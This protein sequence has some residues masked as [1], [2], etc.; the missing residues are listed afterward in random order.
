MP[1]NFPTPLPSNSGSSSDS[2]M[3]NRAPNDLASLSLSNSISL[4]PH[5]CRRAI[6]PPP[7]N[8]TTTAS[9]APQ[10]SSLC[11]CSLLFLECPSLSSPKEICTCPSRFNVTVSPSRIYLSLILPLLSSQTLVNISITAVHPDCNVT[12]D[13]LCMSLPEDGEPLQV[14]DLMCISGPCMMFGTGW[15]LS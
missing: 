1:F 3:A 10:G 4:P 12:H 15:V 8:P 5:L 9:T 13:S 11:L 7:H 14:R 2:V 6:Q